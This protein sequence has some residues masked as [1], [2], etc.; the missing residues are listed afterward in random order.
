VN[1]K[2]RKIVPAYMAHIVF[3]TKRYEEMIEWYK[4]VFHAE[5]MYTSE[6]LTFMTFDDE[7]HRFA[8]LNL[9]SNCPDKN[10]L[11]PAVAHYAFSYAS[12]DD[13]LS[14]YERLKQRS[15]KPRWAIN[16]WVTTSLYY[17]D[18]DGTEVELQL[19][20]HPTPEKSKAVFSSRE[21][22]ANPIG[23]AFDPDTLLR[24]FR[25]GK[26]YADCLE[27]AEAAADPT[28]LPVV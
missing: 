22:L 8:F 2:E 4:I 10:P 13:L 25:S 3:Q 26:P 24:E 28:A 27:A 18:P 19:D 1:E 9:P 7:H 20:N 17:S 23:N 21:Y 6:K 11:S 16:H 14:T 15:I 5:V 12:A